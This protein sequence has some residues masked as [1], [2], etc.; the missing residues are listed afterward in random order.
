MRPGDTCL[1]EAVA[2][3]PDEGSG[4]N[5]GCI[6]SA[7]TF[8]HITLLEIKV[9]KSQQKYCSKKYRCVG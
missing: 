1:W 8:S 5:C 4:T 9:F 3:T 2:L 7:P 6:R